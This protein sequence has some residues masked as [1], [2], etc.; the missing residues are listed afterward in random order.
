LRH[1]L[2][3]RS[4]HC[5]LLEATTASPVLNLAEAITTLLEQLFAEGLVLDGTIAASGQ[6]A[7]EFWRLRESI[8]EAEVHHGG[9][10]KHDIA[11]R[12]S[13]LAAF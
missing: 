13:R 12:T 6:Q 7:A 1:P 3:A 10:V 8:P 2:Q 9:S 4:A 11:V 5:I